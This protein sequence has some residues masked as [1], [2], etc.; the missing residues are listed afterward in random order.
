MEKLV[1][2]NGGTYSAELNKKCTHLVYDVPEGDKYKVAKRWGHIHIVT[3]KWFDQ[4][5]SRKACLS[6]KIYDVQAT[7]TSTS[8]FSLKVQHSQEKLGKPSICSLSSL[9]TDANLRTPTYSGLV[10][11]DV[12]ATLSQ[13]MSSKFPDDPDNVKKE[14]VGEPATLHDDDTNFD[15]CVADDSQKDDNDLYLSDCRISLVGFEALEMRKL[16]SMIRRG[17]GSRY[18][19]LNKNLTHIVVGTP[20]EIEKD[21]ARG[22][23]AAGVISVVKT[24]WL[25]ECDR[26]K[27]EVPVLRRHTGYD[28][29]IPK[30]L[31]SSNKQAARSETVL[32][33]GKSIFPNDQV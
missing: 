25:E 32:K 21:E 5:I 4:S 1:N 14:D 10:G 13:N 3:I 8:K 2:Q 23:A 18:M 12:E 27:K 22:H 15:G 31:V 28:F 30:D 29:L 7:T 6:E 17:G 19:S 26:E 11:S 24:I 20:S 9:D 33:E 16:V